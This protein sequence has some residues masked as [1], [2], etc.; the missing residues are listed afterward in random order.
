MLFIVSLSLSLIVLAAGLFLLAKTKE[1]L[2]KFFKV[3]AWIITGFGI[4][5]AALSIHMAVYKCISHCR[6]DKDGKGNAM[7]F[8]DQMP[9]CDPACCMG[10]GGRDFDDKGCGMKVK[11]MKFKDDDEGEGVETEEVIKVITDSVKLT[12]EQ[13][14]KVREAVEKALK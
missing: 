11:V 6:G 14:K 10:P 4:L 2:G 13:M 3:T 12:P 9:P 8:H 7:F 5:L 1:G